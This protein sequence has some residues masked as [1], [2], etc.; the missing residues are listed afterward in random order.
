MSWKET[1]ERVGEVI[2]GEVFNPWQHRRFLPAQFE[3][4]CREDPKCEKLVRYP[5]R[6]SETTSRV[7]RELK[8]MGTPETLAIAEEKEKFFVNVPRSA[9]TRVYSFVKSLLAAG[10]ADNYVLR[11]I[12]DLKDGAV[13]SAI[14]DLENNLVA[15]KPD[16]HDYSSWS[17]Y[18]FVAK[19]WQL[20]RVLDR[21]SA[22]GVWDAESFRSAIECKEMYV[23]EGIY[24]YKKS[25]GES[26]SPEEILAMS[27]SEV[28]EY[29]KSVAENLET[30]P[31][32][33]G[34]TSFFGERRWNGAGSGDLAFGTSDSLLR[35][36]SNR[37]L[38]KKPEK[39][40]ENE[41]VT[42]AVATMRNACAPGVK[43][44]YDESKVDSVPADAGLEE[45]AQI[46]NFRFE[47]DDEPK[48]NGDLTAMSGF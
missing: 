35:A 22:A 16:K 32:A 20:K 43:L 28:L 31:R 17:E 34:S 47:K 33:Y 38:E 36:G 29:R 19:A 39:K 25:R 18:Q 15:R 13:T 23:K 9:S 3:R 12:E 40:P 6:W 26:V 46:L 37:E 5:W 42:T 45:V 27:W 2:G 14:Y 7:I 10:V 4:D 48:S 8:R 24:Y 44:V 21:I 30:E 11:I 41:S 1:S